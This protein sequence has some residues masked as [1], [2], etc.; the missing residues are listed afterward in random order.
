MNNNKIELYIE[1]LVYGG[2]GLGRYNN[3]V[4]F[5]PDVITGEKTLVEIRTRKKDYAEAE[6]PV[7]AH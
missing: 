1:R 5:V 7:D 2:K 4:V 6:M 3:M